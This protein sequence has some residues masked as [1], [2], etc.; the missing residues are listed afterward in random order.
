MPAFVPTPMASCTGPGQVNCL[1]PCTECGNGV[2]D[3]PEEC[4]DGNDLACDACN[5]CQDVDCGN[6]NPCQQSDC[7][8]NGGCLRL[9]EP[10]G[11]PCGGDVCTGPMTC[12]LGS[13]LT[14]PPPT[15]ACAM[16][17]GQNKV[18]G[19]GNVCT[20][21]DCNNGACTHGQIGGCCNSTPECPNCTQCVDHACE[22]IVD[23][24][25]TDG[26]CDDDNPCTADACNGMGGVQCT[27]TPLSGTQ[28][29]CGTTCRPGTCAA[30]VCNL[31]PPPPC[32]D[33]GLF[34]TGDFLDADGCCVHPPVGGGCC[35][36][37][38][39][40][41]PCSECAGG[42]GHTCVPI[43]NCCTEAQDCDDDNPC[44]DD[45]C[46][47]Q[48]QCQHQDVDGEARPG[49]GAVCNPQT[50][51]EGVCPPPPPCPD[52][53]N[54]C[55]D[56]FLEAGTGC[57]VHP[58]V[59]GE[60]CQ[61]AAECNDG[62][63]CTA[64]GCD[65]GTNRC[66]NVRTDVHCRE[67]QT[68]VD[69][70]PSAGRDL[71]RCGTSLCN[72]AAGICGP[73]TPPDCNDGDFDTLDEC[74][75]DSP[76][77][78]ARCEHRCLTDAACSDGD[79]CSGAETCNDGLCLSSAAL[80]CNDRNPCTDDSCDR[81]QGCRNPPKTGVASILCK[82]TA[83]DDALRGATDADL[84]P[85]LRKKIEKMLRAPRGKVTAAE[86]AERA[87]NV[88]AEGKALKVAAKQLAALA[89][90]VSRQRRV[91]PGLVRALSDAA[92][93]AADAA[94]RVRTNLTP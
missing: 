80:D 53:G 1:L 47:G 62:H 23:C 36:D 74:V 87:G 17:G 65:P 40:C 56:D 71:G 11:T 32:P 34:C 24:C 31:D 46:D 48:M 3:F 30:G 54:P 12:H 38:A 16:E 51:A 18:C 49:C 93:G 75:V 69:C 50:C 10:E 19:D 86:S 64:D 44:T 42:D 45:T 84:K 61:T 52:D 81:A 72:V 85:S 66:T 83:F 59:P 4:D 14:G 9:F 20:T 13:C 70:D 82:L 33:D 15:C 76:T 67:C 91:A 78:P 39:G 35:E 29:G 25:A 5:H 77:G 2:V 27:H 28:T 37:D 22:P 92:R 41:A 55:T 63:T 89:K 57:C 88:K 68:N 6:A 79:A 58:P 90:F 60:C 8:P 7:D 21:D 26:D 73:N 43:P 94:T